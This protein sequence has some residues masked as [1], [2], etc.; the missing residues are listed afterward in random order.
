LENPYGNPRTKLN[1]VQLLSCNALNTVQ[2]DGMNSAELKALRASPSYQ[3][4]LA[5]L[6]ARQRKANKAA[7][8][9]K[10]LRTDSWKKDATR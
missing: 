10:V 4:K 6:I 5:A 2:G 1:N 8:P 9:A 3:N 7:A